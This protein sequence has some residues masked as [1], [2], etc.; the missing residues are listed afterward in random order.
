VS[1]TSQV[2]ERIKTWKPQEVAR[3]LS[4]REFARLCCALD[5]EFKA[6]ATFLVLDISED[7][8]H[9]H[10]VTLIVNGAVRKVKV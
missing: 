3:V 5:T 7:E 2:V 4:L 6:Y 10:D 1:S 8:T 9:R